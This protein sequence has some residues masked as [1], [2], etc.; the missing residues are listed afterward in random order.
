VTSLEKERAAGSTFGT[1]LRRHRIAAGLSQEALAE[2]AR[3]SAVGIGALE[4]GVRQS[5]Y[6]DTVALLATALNLAPAAATEL[7]AAAVRRRGPRACADSKT[8]P[9]EGGPVSNLPLARTNLV[10]REDEI[11]AIVR[12]VGQSRLVSIV[13]AGGIGKTRVAIAAAR[14]LRERAQ[15]EVLL[16]ELAALATGSFVA[17]AVAQVL[18][19]QESPDRPLIESLVGHLKHKSLLLIVDNC[20]HVIAH[21]AGLAETLLSRC[22]GLRILATSREPLRIGGERIYRLP[23]LPVPSSRE[24]LRVNAAG[25]AA[26]PAL[27]LFAER[28]RAGADGFV[29]SDENA[30]IVAQICRRLEGIPLAIELAAARLKHMPIGALFKHLDGRL[31]ILTGG[32]RTAHA[33]HQTMRALI[34][35]S[36]DLLTVPEQRLFERLSIFAS[37][38]DLASATAINDETAS[39]ELSVLEIISSLVDKSLLVADL[40][41][42]QPRYRLL[43]S[44]RDYAREKLAARGDAALVARRHAQTYLELAQRLRREFL[45][46]PNAAWFACAALELEN[47]RSALEWTLAARGD[48]VLGLRLADATTPWWTFFSPVEGYRY[49]V[50]ALALADERT[51]AE[52]T[53][54]AENAAAGLALVFG[55]FEEALARSRRALSVLRDE[56]NRIGAARAQL[57]IG[58]SLVNLARFDEGE[59]L[60]QSALEAF[61]SLD[62]PVLVATAL[63]EIALVRGASGDIPGA[64]SYVSEALAIFDRIGG[65]SFVIVALGALAEIEFRAGNAER[66]A[67]LMPALPPYVPPIFLARYLLAL[68]AYLIACDRWDDARRHAGEALRLAHETQDDT[69]LAWAIQHFAA[70][71]AL[72]NPAS[73]AC[74]PKRWLAVRDCWV[75][76]THGSRDWARRA[77]MRNGKNTIALSPCCVTKSG[78]TT[79]RTC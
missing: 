57:F 17:P 77:A 14:A 68:A 49:L 61:R 48:I 15:A 38:C 18:K 76:S 74:R 67:A 60:L 10:G 78:L 3:M 34:D 47:W 51:P 30:A 53:A 75:T 12:M 22:S 56:D 23:P 42:P 50:S 55:N 41:L 59:P 6:R 69:R 39:D 7:E 21:A 54:N 29:L 31:R 62:S 73:T 35:W 25:A 64:R 52:V 20:E 5:P 37:G 8:V 63:Q 19:L 33:R 66:A 58:R 28:A 13:G 16:V 71:I 40:A 1:L 79:W 45:V 70:V 4:R 26:F 43:E 32:E 65:D 2:R 72:A 27:V 36:Y 11:G 9:V 24:A 44:T 46:A